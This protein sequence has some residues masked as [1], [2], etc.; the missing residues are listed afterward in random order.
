M[1]ASAL[2]SHYFHGM[3][4]LKPEPFITV[5]EYLEGELISEVRQEYVGGKVLSGLQV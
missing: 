5:E 1:L 2:N 4:A 3:G